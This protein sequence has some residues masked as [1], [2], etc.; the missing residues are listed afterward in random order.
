MPIEMSRSR[1]TTAIA[2]RLD[3]RWHFDFNDFDLD[4]ASA[5]TFLERIAEQLQSEDVWST[6][7]LKRLVKILLMNVIAASR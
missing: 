5:R 4:P 7:S 2:Q 3:A 1:I 6:I